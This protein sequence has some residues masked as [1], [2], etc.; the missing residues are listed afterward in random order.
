[1][2]LQVLVVMLLSCDGFGSEDTAVPDRDE[3]D[4][5]GPPAEQ[6]ELITE[7]PTI[8]SVGDTGG[9]TTPAVDEDGDGYA[10]YSEGGADCDDHDATVF[11]GAEEWC[12]PVDHDC[13]GEILSFGVCGKG[14]LLDAVAPI[15]LTGVAETSG[16]IRIVGDLTGDGISDLMG[17][18][19]GDGMW[20]PDGS[21]LDDG[22]YLFAGAESFGAGVDLLGDAATTWA[23]D[24]NFCGLTQV[25][26]AGDLDGDGIGDVVIPVQS[27]FW[28]LYVHLGPVSAMPTQGW[29]GDTE[30]R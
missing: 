5:P 1:V 11:E 2:I 3:P 24:P 4:G 18:C 30:T 17:T 21:E 9:E 19:Y 27:C 12:D 23:A 16:S 7:R 25:I 6:A 15:A 22:V 28:G 14:Q 8:G 29:L 20:R 13:D 26:D 10:P